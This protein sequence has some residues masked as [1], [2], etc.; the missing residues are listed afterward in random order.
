MVLD[1]YLHSAEAHGRR[2]DENW[3]RTLGREQYDWLRTTL[4]ASPA[5]LKFVFVHHL[6][7]GLDGNARG[8]TE[9]AGLYEWGGHDPD[10][11]DTF[12]EHRPGW[13]MPIHQLLVEHGVSAVFHGHD[14][15]YARQERDGI[16]YQLVPQPGHPGDTKLPR[17]AAEYGYRSGDL[18][19][20]SGHLRIRVSRD[21]ATVDYV[22]AGIGASG[23]AAPDNGHVAFSYTLAPRPVAR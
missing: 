1:P 23:A 16:V 9:A 8:G 10:G 20:G 15:F 18:L 19:G 21:A 3:G 11:A 2:P 14:H 22:L 7:G 17:F 4:A 13:P 12:A 6:V 5:R